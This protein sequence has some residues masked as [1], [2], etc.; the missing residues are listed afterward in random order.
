MD[1]TLQTLV[2]TQ[3]KL[4]DA[5]VRLVAVAVLPDRLDTLR[6][7]IASNEEDQQA[8]KSL[9]GIKILPYYPE[10]E[11]GS[12]VLETVDLIARSYDWLQ[13]IGINL[14]DCNNA[15]PQQDTIR[16]MLF[17]KLGVNY[18]RMLLE[19][20]EAQQRGHNV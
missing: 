12:Q 3:V 14:R 13:E 4:A 6:Q 9:V 7:A 1:G 19:Q 18:D 15:W 20:A 8:A 16:K 10:L 2:Q 5:G 11:K 17:T